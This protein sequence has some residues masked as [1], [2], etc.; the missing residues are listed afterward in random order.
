MTP[1]R[2][3]RKQGCWLGT[4]AARCPGS[5]PL[6]R[7]SSPQQGVL[8]DEGFAFSLLMQNGTL[9]LSQH[10]ERPYSPYRDLI[11]LYSPL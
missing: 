2:T 5:H 11:D 3:V 7:V 1:K 8:L 4:Q 10:L 6:G 9:V